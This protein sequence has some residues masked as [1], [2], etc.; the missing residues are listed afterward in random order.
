MKGNKDVNFQL[1]IP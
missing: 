1:L